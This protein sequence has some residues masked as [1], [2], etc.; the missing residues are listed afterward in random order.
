MA[1]KEAGIEEAAQPRYRQVYNALHRQLEEQQLRPGA[2]IP[3]DRELVERFAVSRL[4]IAK[5]ISQLA[6]EGYLERRPGSG[7]YVTDWARKRE[8][9]AAL[10]IAV[11]VPFAHDDF[12]T[13]LLK[14]V[15]DSLYDYEATLQFFDSDGN[16]KK[17]AQY[18]RRLVN[19]PAE[20]LIAFPISLRENQDLY[21]AYQES[22]RPLVFL[23]SYYPT[24]EGDRV[25]TDNMQGGYLATKLLIDQGHKVIGHLMPE[26]MR[27]PALIDRRLGYARALLE[28][29]MPVDAALIREIHSRNPLR[30]DEPKLR[31]AHVLN[32]WRQLAAPPTAVFCANDWILQSC[33]LA[34]RREGMTV[35]TDMAVT[36]FCDSDSWLRGMDD[37]F[38]GVRQQ[39]GILGRRAVELLVARLRPKAG[40]T[41]SG[42]YQHISIPP[43]LWR[44]EGHVG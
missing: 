11:L 39:T 2:R 31:C 20:G 12:V 13:Q 9:A 4:T 16:P 34:L 36:G 1:I 24:L 14:A 29:G 17:E 41:P 15:S 30:A 32:S 8:S 26:E 25:V 18:L 43:L 27:N 22:G 35:P 5:A 19:Q 40:K 38:E 6:D 21:R 10:H 23:D 44:H 42:A 28:A 3:P 33:L 7:T 37:P